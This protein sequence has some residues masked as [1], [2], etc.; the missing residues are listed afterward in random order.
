MKR[1]FLLISISFFLSAASLWMVLGAFDQEGSMNALGYAAGAIFWLGL[2]VGIA[3]YIFCFRKAYP[4]PNILK[5]FSNKP[6]KV[7]DGIL[8]VSAAVTIY[9]ACRVETNEL[10]ILTAVFL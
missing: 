2:F 4:G 7:T 1:K 5:F 3:G 6:A 8:I 10:V 9:G